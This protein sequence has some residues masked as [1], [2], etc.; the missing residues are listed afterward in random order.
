MKEQ[1]EPNLRLWSVGLL[2]AAAALVGAPSAVAAAPRIA[3]L[4]PARVLTATLWTAGKYGHDQRR[5]GLVSGSEDISPNGTYVAAGSPLGSYLE[6]FRIGG[7]VRKYVDLNQERFVGWTPDS[8]YFAVIISEAGAQYLEVIDVRTGTVKFAVQ[9][10]I[11]ANIATT[12]PD[13]IVYV[14]QADHDEIYTRNPSGGALRRLRRGEGISCS[15][16]DEVIG[17]SSIVD[18]PQY[19]ISMRTGTVRPLT[20]SCGTPPLFDD[21]SKSGRRL[22]IDCSR[23][24]ATIPTAGGRTTILIHGAYDATWTE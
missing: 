13:R 4:K 20:A 16:W 6:V 5:L 10:V 18:A 21:V 15:L 2:A 12:R 22:L 19:L 17:V 3:Y 11:D 23:N 24:I 8:R 9:G 14:T 7:G 1:Q